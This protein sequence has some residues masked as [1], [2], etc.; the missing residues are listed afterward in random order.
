LMALLCASC[1]VLTTP[2]PPSVDISHSS[3]SIKQD[4]STLVPPLSEL[5]LWHYLPRSWSSMCTVD[6]ANDAQVN[7]TIGC[8]IPRDDKPLWRLADL[9]PALEPLE[10]ALR[11][12]V[13]TLCV[14]QPA[15]KIK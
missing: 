4:N 1:L 11:L 2:T 3:N 15:N 12:K 13:K 10:S 8:R 7:V 14:A 6:Y 9:R 5:N